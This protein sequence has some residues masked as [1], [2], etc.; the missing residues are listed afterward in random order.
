MGGRRVRSSVGGA[1]RIWDTTLPR[2]TFFS[3]HG[4]TGL[5][6]VRIAYFG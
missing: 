1:V 6:E 5:N 3:S 4:T 2:R